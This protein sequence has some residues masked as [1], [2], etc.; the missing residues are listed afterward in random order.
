MFEEFMMW[1][2]ASMAL[3]V[4][5]IMWFYAIRRKPITFPPE[6]ICD[7]CGQVCSELKEGYCEY[8]EKQL[9]K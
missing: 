6:W 2:Y 1:F 8:C 4:A 7:G 3:M 9:A 5:A